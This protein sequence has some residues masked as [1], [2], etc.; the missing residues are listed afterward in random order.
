ML[1]Y[2][3]EKLTTELIQE[4]LPLQEEYWRQVA[5]PFHNFPPDVDWATYLRAEE[6]GRL[7]FVVGREEGEVRGGA[8][9]VL[10]PHPHYAC[11]SASLPLL[12]IHP[13]QRY[14]REGFRLL[15]LAEDTAAKAGAQMLMTHGGIHNG[16]AKLFEATHYQDFGRYFV[17]VIGSAKPVFKKDL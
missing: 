2:A 9:I 8:F 4:L 10:G 15:K 14:G 7:R 11:I 17:K 16:V 1:E 12:F 5:G 3:V 6:L 13:D